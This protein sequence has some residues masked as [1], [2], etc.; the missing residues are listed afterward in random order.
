MDYLLGI[1]LGTQSV[2]SCLFDL[3]GA[4]CASA[5]RPLRMTYPHP[6]WA[7]QDPEEWWD[8]ALAA[9]RETLERPGV[10]PAQVV[11]L[12]PDCTACTVV[13]LDAEGK[14]LRPALLWMDE[15]AHEEAE[16]I[17]R[18]QHPSFRYCGG[19]LSPQWMLPKARWL[20]RYEPEVYS[21]A[22]WLVDGVDFLTYR[23]TGHWTASLNTVTAKWNYVRPLGGWPADLLAEADLEDLR[24]KWPEKILPVGSK[25]G[26]LH[27]RVAAAT[28]L[29]EETVVAQGGIDAYAGMIGV[30][31]VEP[32]DLAV[33]VGSSSCHLAL[34]KKPVFADIWGP[35]PD[36]LVEGTYVLEGGQTATGSIVQWLLD[37][38]GAGRTGADAGGGDPLARLEPAAEKIRPGA[39]GLLLL[40]H[41][42]GNRTPYKD[43]RARGVIIGLTLRHG[44]PHL[45]RGIYEAVT[46]GTRQVLE[47]MAAHGFAPAKLFAGGGGARSALWMQIH[48]DVLGQPIHLTREPESVA[49][50]AAIW[51]GM[52]AGRFRGYRDATEAMVRTERVVAPQAS[53]RETYDFYYKQ[54]LEAYRALRDLEHRLAM[55][56]AGRR[57]S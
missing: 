17:S 13:A 25:V 6:G 41:F 19:K 56:E 39:E 12:S 11:A 55:F 7:E 31:A 46:Y 54:Y 14:P 53:R 23:L 4:M 15:R 20:K 43:P 49:L 57:K 18:L 1:D 48:A 8:A 45:L 51:A 35:Y 37:I 36:A 21:K 52:A 40:D 33:I 2:R 34:S 3:Q 9:I 22:I 27:P 30:G 26:T 42:Q 50:G 38:A 28:G 47:N 16:E 10:S 5:T 32:G 29:P 44:L 24:G